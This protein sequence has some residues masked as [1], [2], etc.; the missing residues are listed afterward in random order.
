MM[1]GN[2]PH[3]ANRMANQGTSPVTCGRAFTP[4]LTLGRA[5]SLCAVIFFCLGGGRAG[6]RWLCGCCT[7]QAPSAIVGRVAV[8]AVAARVL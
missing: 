6:C 2:Y 1:G 4:S 3:N 7:A 8:I 5:F